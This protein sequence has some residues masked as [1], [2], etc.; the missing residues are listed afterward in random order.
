MKKIVILGY[1]GRG[2]GYADLCTSLK[3]KNDFELV[4]II[5]SN[6]EKLKVAKARHNLSDSMLFT[7]L[8]EFC[9]K[10]CMADYMFVCTQDKQHYEHCM[11]AL[12]A[13][14]NLI[15]E[16]PI[17]CSLKECIE[18]RDKANEK[19]LRVAV[20]HVLRYSGYYTKIKEIMDSGV[21]GK[22]IAIEQIENV[23]YW[24]Q[25]HSFVRGDWRNSDTS[26]PMIIAKCCHD[27]DIAVY[28]SNSECE[29]VQS[30]GKLNYFNKEN[31]PKGATQY[32]ID[33]C[34]CKDNCPYDAEKIYVDT[35][36]KLPNSVIK[37]MWPHSRLMSD[38]VV[39]KEKV[40]KALHNTDFGKCVF[41]M[42]NNVVDYEQT[43]ISFK[44]GITSTLIMTAFSDTIYRETRIRG[45][46][47]ELICSTEKNKFDLNLFGKRRKKVKI[48]RKYLGS[49]GGGDEGLINALANDTLNT[50]INK[51]VESHIIGFCAEESR[52]NSGKTIFLDSFRK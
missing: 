7:S 12:D 10:P 11:L 36:K 5:D 44:N 52:K 28:L 14:Y 49:H 43:T 50:D 30:I 15:L 41:A 39:T 19:K 16:K 24:H 9:R 22:I 6:V 13:G 23:G 8:E 51:S 25:A 34:K 45:T 32:C 3:H 37:Y 35:I 38:G 4:A 47:G 31:M 1:G 20:C 42:D 17:A 48:S 33:G 40:K 46:K 26:T 18:I 2:K 29:M 27:L 21:L